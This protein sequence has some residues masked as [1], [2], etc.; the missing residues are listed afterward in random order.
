MR[1]LSFDI[2]IK[3]LAFCDVSNV[4]KLGEKSDDSDSSYGP[5]NSHSHSNS[6]PTID[7]PSMYTFH[8]WQVLD[9]SIPDKKHDINGVVQVILEKLDTLFTDTIHNYDAILIENQ[10]VLKNPVMKSIQMIIFTFFHMR[11][12]E[13]Y[14]RKRKRKGNEGEN[15]NVNVNRIQE[16]EQEHEQNKNCIP[17]IHLI[18]ASNK[19]KSSRQLPPE[20]AKEIQELTEL[21]AKASKGYKFNKKMAHN[22]TLAFLDSSIVNKDSMLCEYKAHKKKD[23]LA[24][25][26]L[27]AAYFIDSEKK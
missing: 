18:S 1:V 9:I 5:S 12:K 2:G 3:N 7:G 10:P 19:C 24:D 14:K 6:G 27:Q 13:E 16:Q 23:D 4:C 11:V 8:D 25:C 21:E 26:F 15:V 22:L 17:S 20:K